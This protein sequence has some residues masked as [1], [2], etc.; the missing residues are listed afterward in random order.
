MTALAPSGWTR[1]GAALGALDRRA[2]GRAIGL[3][4][5]NAAGLLCREVI[6]YDL[7]MRGGFGAPPAEGARRRP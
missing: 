3:V 6:D 1:G 4:G 2:R 5:S 7:S